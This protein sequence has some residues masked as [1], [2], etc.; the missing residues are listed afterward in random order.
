MNSALHSLI[1]SANTLETERVSLR[2]KCEHESGSVMF[3]VFEEE[4]YT[5]V[6]HMSRQLK[7]LFHETIV[8][9]DRMSCFVL[10]ISLGLR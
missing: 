8:N 6:R 4:Q 1:R 9:S 10:I 7:C 5:F 3:E 2:I